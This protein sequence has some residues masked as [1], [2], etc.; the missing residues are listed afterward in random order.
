MFESRVAELGGVRH[1]RRAS[2][3]C[4][5]AAAVG[6]LT[7]ISFGR[8]DHEALVGA[9][10]EPFAKTTGIAVH[11]LSYDG[12]VTELTQMVHAGAASTSC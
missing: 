12:Q 1:G 7:V 8:A 10:V 3:Y 2:A 5:A 6:E 11:S 9:Y 4:A